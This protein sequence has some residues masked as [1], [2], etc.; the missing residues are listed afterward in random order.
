MFFV[1]DPDPFG[2]ELKLRLFA[3]F[4]TAVGKKT[5]VR[6]YDELPSVGTVLRDL[7]D[8]YPELEFY[9]SDGE[10][11]QYLA[12]LV[13]G[14]DINFLDGIDTMVEDGDDVSIFPPVAGGSSNVVERSFRGISE[15]AAMHYL[16]RI[17]GT[18]RDT[19][20]VEGDGWCACLSS[21]PVSIGPT[22]RVTEVT[23]RL[24]G[25]P[26]AINTVLDRFVRKALRAGG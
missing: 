5:L 26:E 4:R 1:Y 20:R 16:E 12:V 19:S 17:G 22:L 3:N 15:R 11:R 24:V 23:I 6:Q 18:R 25:D 14:R 10:L 9:T 2:M 7:S 8:E 21:A 13:N